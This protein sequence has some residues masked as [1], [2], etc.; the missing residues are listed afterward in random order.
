[1]NRDGFSLLA[2][3]FT[4]KKALEW[5]LKFLAAFN[6]MEQTL[7]NQQNLSW[8]EA[9]DNNKLARR[10]ETDTI[11][12]FVEYATKQGSKN[13]RKYFINLTTMTYRALFLVYEAS[14]KPFRDLLDVAQ[15]SFLTTAEY[16]IQAA[17]EEGMTQSMFYKD[18]YQLARDRVTGYA[19]QLPKH[20]LEVKPAQSLLFS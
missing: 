14:P 2:M 16:L 20:R 8:K 3:G 18:I 4:G 5:K 12:E 15:M 6:L 17:L 13:A 10:E 11:V 19:V 9:R 1:M 7:L